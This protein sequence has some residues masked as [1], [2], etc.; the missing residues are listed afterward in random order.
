MYPVVYMA[1]DV[2][3]LMQENTI[4]RATGRGGPRKSRLFLG[5]KMAMSESSAI[6]TLKSQDFQ[7]PPLSMALQMYFPTPRI[8][9]ISKRKDTIFLM[10]I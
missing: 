6:W 1:R 10:Y 9:K 2:M 8:R 7:G 3:I 4:W 5:P